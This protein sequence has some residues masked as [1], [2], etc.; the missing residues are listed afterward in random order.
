VPAPTL[1]KID[2]DGA[3]AAV[4]DGAAGT[5]A[6]PEL[7]SVLVEIARA[8]GDAV[9]ETLRAADLELTERVDERS[10][11]RLQNVWY[12]VFDRS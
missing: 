2:V 8:G 3:E 12:G 10:G 9:A 4:L 7:R 6:R 1:L 11:E 5:L